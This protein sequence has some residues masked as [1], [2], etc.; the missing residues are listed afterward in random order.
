MQQD[1][2]G[3]LRHCQ[4]RAIRDTTGEELKDLEIGENFRQV[5]EK[6]T[7]CIYCTTLI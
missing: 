6:G 5:T 3:I 4:I 1:I 2:S 7:A